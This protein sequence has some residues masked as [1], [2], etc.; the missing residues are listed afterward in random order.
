MGESR[1]AD[2]LSSMEAVMW[3]VCR[4]AAVRMTVGALTVRRQSVRRRDRMAALLAGD[5]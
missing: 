3:R 1:V 2:E 4:N 5:E